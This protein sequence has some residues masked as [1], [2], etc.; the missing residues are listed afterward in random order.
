LDA[1]IPANTTA[2]I[3]V[4]AKDAASVTESGQP[5]AR[6][7]GVTLLRTEPGLVVFHVG[8]G[9]YQFGSLISPGHTNLSNGTFPV[10]NSISN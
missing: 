4:P 9:S 2:T 10:E 3:F 7:E 1:S 6:A 8:S 5:A